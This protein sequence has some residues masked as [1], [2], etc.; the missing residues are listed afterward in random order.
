M[1]LLSTPLFSHWS[2]PLKSPKKGVGSGVGSGVDPDP[3]PDPLVRGTDSRIRT[4]MSRIPDTSFQS[5]LS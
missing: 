1:I 3:D 4:K 2:I 5:R